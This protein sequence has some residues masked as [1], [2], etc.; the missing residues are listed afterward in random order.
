MPSVKPTSP[1]LR[2]PVLIPDDSIFPGVVVNPAAR[3]GV[4]STMPT[5][6]S[7]RIPVLIPKDAIFP[8]VGLNPVF[9][10]DEVLPA[11]SVIKLSPLPSVEELN[12]FL[13]LWVIYLF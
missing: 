2:I 11:L 9:D 4:P 1:P 10:N 6:S 12:S 7:S 13:H 5:S 8:G 3:P